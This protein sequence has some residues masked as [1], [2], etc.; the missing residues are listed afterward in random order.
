ML[1]G[2]CPI[3]Y[4]LKVSFH[5][6]KIVLSCFKTLPRSGA[7]DMARVFTFFFFLKNKKEKREG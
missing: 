6:P 1:Q 2:T 7:L 3:E 5:L 4:V